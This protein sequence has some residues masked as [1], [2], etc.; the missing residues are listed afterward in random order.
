MSE[1]LPEMTRG[2]YN[3]PQNPVLWR[4]RAIVLFRLGFADLAAGDAYKAIQLLSKSNDE[5]LSGI[6]LDIEAASAEAPDLKMINYTWL[7]IS[8][9]DTGDNNAAQAMLQK[10]RAMYPSH[11]DLKK[12]EQKVLIELEQNEKSR[13]DRLAT[14]DPKYFS[15][16]SGFGSVRHL[17]YPFIPKAFLSRSEALIQITNKEIEIEAKAVFS[18]CSLRSSTV[19]DPTDSASSGAPSALGIFATRD[20]R[21]G[22]P[23]IIDTPVLAATENY[24]RS[25]NATE[26]CDNCYGKIPTNGP[27]KRSASCCTVVYCSQKCK[28]L[29]WK[30]YHQVLCK[31]DFNWVWDDSKTGRSIYDLDGPM[32]LRILAV[33]VQSKTHPLEHPLI[34]SLTPLYDERVGRRWS[35]SNNIVMPNKILQQLGIDTYVD[36]RYDTWVLQTIW[37]RNITN[38]HWGHSV[39]GVTSLRRCLGTELAAMR[40]EMSFAQTVSRHQPLKQIVG[41]LFSC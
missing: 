8:L 3:Y 17:A 31:Q 36:S 4:L 40:S 21:E 37:A 11:P 24:G 6:P 9:I 2:I 19:Q 16:A 1:Q 10:A 38:V 33:C 5:N 12:I 26:I 22:F 15:A 41:L 29:A 30:H 20:I 34:A 32:W 14:M 35:L 7:V 27:Q 28:D 39:S 13:Q 25:C 23:F 18:G